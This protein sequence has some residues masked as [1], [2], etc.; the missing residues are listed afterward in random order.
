MN[1]EYICIRKLECGDEY[2]FL[3]R[4][5]RGSSEAEIHASEETANFLNEILGVPF[6]EE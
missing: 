1:L 2:I 3:V 4:V 5:K 6:C